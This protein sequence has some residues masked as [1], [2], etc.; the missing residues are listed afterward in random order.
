MAQ[1][2]ADVNRLFGDIVKVTPTSKVVGDLALYMVANEL[3]PAQ[4][5]D[6]DHPVDFPESVV[7]LFRGELGTPPEGW[8][9]ALQ[10]KVLKGAQP[11]RGR[12]GASIPPADLDAARREAAKLTGG[13]VT[14]S[15]LASY[16]M[17]PKLFRDYAEHVKRYG[18]VSALPTPVFFY[19]MKEQQDEI[20]V[21]LEPG[22]TLVIR[23]LS[24]TDLPDEAA[25]RLFFELNGQPRTI[26]VPHAGASAAAARPKAG[27]HPD[28]I[29]APMPGMVVRVAVKPGDAV[30]QGEP[31]I[32][33]EAMKMETLIA[34][35]RDARVAAVHV[36]PGTAVEAKDLLIELA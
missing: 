31:L 9:A 6:P 33:L 29:G 18:E 1:A 35:P 8:P 12:P 5:A 13:E 19:G 15:D 34:A 22:K 14:D 17:Y 21:D 4:I 3:T 10:K 30:K 23:L 28:Q 16:L 11:I 26:R 20:S 24:R 27:D 32:A 25:S 2:Y 7:A 36:K